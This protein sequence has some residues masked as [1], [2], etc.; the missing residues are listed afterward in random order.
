MGLI[1]K[2]TD[3]S[4]RSQAPLQNPA[5]LQKPAP[6]HNRSY[7]S[8]LS[9][10]GSSGEFLLTT[11]NLL[12]SSSDAHAAADAPKPHTPRQQPMPPDASPYNFP[13][14]Q[15][16]TPERTHRR[17][18]SFDLAKLARL[19]APRPAPELSP[20]HAPAPA[21]TANSLVVSFPEP[22]SRALPDS[23]KHATQL[24]QQAKFFHLAHYALQNTLDPYQNYLLYMQAPKK[25]ES[26]SDY[27]SDDNSDL[28]A[29]SEALAAHPYADQWRQYYAAMAHQQMVRQSMMPYG[30][31][32][33]P[34]YYGQPASPGMQMHPQMMMQMQMMGYA[35]QH[36]AA[37]Y[38]M[39][40]TPTGDTDRSRRSTLKSAR[41]PSVPL[42]LIAA[43]L[44]H[45]EIKA[46]V[47][48]VRR[49]SLDVGFSPKPFSEDTGAADALDTTL[50]D[51]TIGAEMDA[52]DPKAHDQL[53]ESTVPAAPALQSVA[54]GLLD[55]GIEP[56]D[57]RYISDYNKMFFD[58]E[59]EKALPAP[60]ELSR[61][62]SLSSTLSYNSI[63]SG[64]SSKF[65]VG[66]TSDRMQRMAAN[67]S[68]TPTS[69]DELPVEKQPVKKLRSQRFKEKVRSKRS[70]KAAKARET[71]GFAT[72]PPR[73]PVMP[74]MLPMMLNNLPAV[75]FYSNP[76]MNFSTEYQPPGHARSQSIATADAKRR[77]MMMASRGLVVDPFSPTGAAGK[78][79]T[80]PP[81]MGVPM[82]Q[83]IKTSDPTIMKKI[84]EFVA[85]RGVIASGNKSL[86][87]RL[88][89]IKMLVTATNYKLYAYINI[90]GEPINIDQAQYNKALFVKLA[91][92]H[93]LKMVREHETKGRGPPEIY[94]EVYFIYGCFLKHDYAAYYNQD[95]G[96][97]K[98]VDDALKY[99]EMCTELNPN[100]FKAFYR[101]GDLYEYEVPELF[102]QAVTC[103]RQLAKLGYNRAIYKIAM[104]CLNEP[105]VRLPRFFNYLM[106]LSNIDLNSKDI[107]L[108]D[109][110]MD[111]LEEV[112]GLAC[113]QLGRIYEGMYPGDLTPEDPFIVKLLELAPVNYAKALTYYNR[114]GKLDCLLA[115]VK[116][117]SVYEYGEL[118]RQHNPN[119]SIQ[120]YIKALTL[121]LQ[122][123]RHPDAMLG[124]ARWCLQGS[125]GAS[126]HIPAPNPEK[127]VMW[128]ERAAKEFQT[129]D[130]FFAMG[131]LVE[132]GLAIG[133]PQVWF[134]KAHKLGHPDAAAKLGF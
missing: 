43:A 38:D 84:E 39:P 56:E 105:S 40:R 77:S 1:T 45:A 83:A 24:P 82:A 124:L 125:D 18:S 78:R 81:M 66:S 109:D 117:G 110:D 61:Q 65:V 54:Y 37:P 36:M 46:K 132:Q 13:A 73:P 119:K 89:W 104:L 116:L 90:K 62:Q 16:P 15:P 42:S 31:P 63:Q 94:A 70:D 27:T 29:A 88:K 79:M 122:F 129:P 93:L 14:Q 103:F 131:E 127:A 32:M 87:Y 9:L 33:M 96:V 7:T 100:H 120:W 60:P 26:D 2:F 55:L 17:N 102:E 85:L 71:G 64:A 23:A 25:D 69:V 92:T 52:E 113:Y 47:K 115:Q 11:S 123:R 112:V 12:C 76:M 51:L 95:F 98:N 99:F 118:N 5:G 133:N 30:Y 134:Q 130:T 91:T 86:E 35:P 101:L 6:L 59:P 21:S 97:A 58:D 68:S 128:T 121:P 67:E 4:R 10:T 48:S 8:L 75:D 106:N 107:A 72:P 20:A 49:P 3:K 41:Y 53:P 19:M 111:E 34:Q 80:M 50:A 44:E 28:D 22:E 57:K 74:A 126:K 114:A 108:T